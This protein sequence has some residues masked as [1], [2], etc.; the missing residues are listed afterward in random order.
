M[1]GR[2]EYRYHAD[3][4]AHSPSTTWKFEKQFGDKYNSMDFDKVEAFF[5]AHVRVKLLDSSNL[6]P[7]ESLELSVMERTSILVS[8]YEELTGQKLK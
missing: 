6:T 3:L 2:Q 7:L 5:N 1:G 4:R 8:E